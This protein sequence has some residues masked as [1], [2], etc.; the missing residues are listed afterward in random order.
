MRTMKL[1]Q[2]VTIFV[3][4]LAATTA[5]ETISYAR[6]PALAPD[7]Q[8]IAFTYRGDIWSVPA[9]GGKA[10]RLTVNV[11][12]DIRPQYSPDGKWLMF[13]SRRDNNYDVFIMP[14]EGGPARQLTYSSDYD[15]G[16]G[17]FPA[18]DS[19]LFTS[20]R[21]GRGDIFKV[22][23]DGGAPIKL[24]AYNESREYDA[25]ISPDRRWILYNNGSGP[26]RWWRRDL[27]ATKNSDLWLL[28]RSA[29]EY[30]SERITTWKNHDLWPVLD[31]G[32]GTIYFVSNHDED[33]AQVYAVSHGTE[34]TELTNFTG[35]GVQWLNSNPQGDMLVFE[36]DFK[37]WTL[38][39][40]TKELKEVPIE[41][42]TDEAFNRFENQSLAG[43]IEW[44]SLSPDEKKVAVVAHGEAF[45]LAA[46]N[47]QTARQVTHTSA[48]ERYPVWGQDS[49][50]L[51]YVSDR[52]GNYD[53]FSL[54]VVSGKEQQLTST[55]ANETKPLVSPD[56][57][58]L[59]Y[60]RGLD[61]IMRR[62][63]TTGVETV[64][65]EGDFFD[66]GV[67]TA[68]QY[69]WSP[70]SRWLTFVMAGP[71]YETNIFL[72]S[73]DGEVHNI[74][75][76][77][78]WNYRP[79]F[80]ADGKSVYFSS[81]FDGKDHTYQVDLEHKPTEFVEATVD[82]L[83]LQ[84][85]DKQAE[86]S[87]TIAP[88]QVDFDNITAR[89]H[90][91]FS[92]AGSSEW[93]VLTPDS[94][95]FIF[96]SSLLGKS[97]IW[98]VNTEEKPELTQLTQSG[99]GKS[100]LSVTSDG[101]H[102]Y[103]LEDGQVKSL[104]LDSKKLATLEFAPT[105]EVDLVANNKQRFNEAWRMLRDYFYDPTLHGADWQVVREKYE[106]LLNDIRTEPEFDN[107][108]NEVMGELRGSHLDI[109]P[110]EPRP[111]HE[112]QTGRTG[113]YIDSKL[114]DTQGRYLVTDVLSDSPAALCGIKPGG[115]I[116]TVDGVMLKRETNLD[117]LLLGTIGNRVKLT[118]ADSPTAKS[119]EVD[120]KPVNTGT[121]NN[122]WYEDWV[123]SRRRLVDSLSQ[124]RL[125]YIHIRAM[126]APALER[127]KE[128]LVGI[129][130]PKD[131]LIVDV[132]NNPGGSIAVH[133][134]GMLERTPFVLRNFRHFPTTSENKMRSKA[135]EKPL[136]LLINN[137]SGSNSEIFAEGF[138]KLEL[139]PIIGEPT[140]GAVIGTSAYTLIDGTRVRR[141][142]WGSYTTEMED[143]D[144]APRQPDILVADTPDDL[145]NGRDPQLV[146][147]VQELMKDLK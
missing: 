14:A 140:A 129:A 40:A 133:L 82:S 136:A 87:E 74:T 30:K 143:T 19:V 65:V 34:P 43:E 50:T 115:Y 94:K 26:Y 79:K 64:W 116:M 144:L 103:F 16:T 88:V 58:Y 45:I 63:L 96:V 48:R 39:P 11:A 27:R 75:Q 102:A 31:Y 139:G 17:W 57:K 24:T 99:K 41:I 15:V 3:I 117:S 127:F 68:Y 66:L 71:T 62:D 1:P 112:Q 38:D 18:S 76:F 35:D 98:S 28:D 36:Q 124:G 33:W 135:F 59:A 108:M 73:L 52:D 84:E 60:Y 91:S 49:Q 13:S 55:E 7:N 131:G 113:F 126:N 54:D 23:I 138:R 32:T 83:F 120:L 122:L 51:Y 109:Y 90:Q 137:Y 22:S 110:R 132:R 69:D 125:A 2:I 101:K 12:E 123:R 6:Y 25:H 93:P 111:T 20:Y 77:D 121:L 142:S 44:Y 141:P 107:F 118:I 145:M 78:G 97:E 114:L 134:L 56:G 85:P 46:D 89:R 72:V 80:A 21:D 119:R 92:L 4:F 105:L 146:R 104:D 53:L 86:D 128:E 95:Q 81:W 5:A 47:P 29:P 100:F 37:I 106:P 70:D 8:T 42:S 10:T 61:R 67:E 9:T 147:A 130:E